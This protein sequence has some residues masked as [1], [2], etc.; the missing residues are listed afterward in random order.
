M[1]VFANDDLD[2]AQLRRRPAAADLR[3]RAPTPCCTRC[4]TSTRHTRGGMQ[5]RWRHRRLH[6]RRRARTA[7]RATCSASRTAP[8]TRDARRRRRWTRLVWVSRSRRAGMG[9]GRQLPRRPRHP[10]ARR[11]LGP[12]DDRAS[13][14]GCSA[15]ARTPARRCTGSRRPTPRLRRRPAGAAI[16][17]DA[18]IRMANPRTAGDA[19]AAASCAAAT[20]TTGARR[21]GNLDMGLVFNCFQQDL[22]RQFVAVQKR[23][24]DEPLVDYMSPVGGGY[25]FALP[26]VRDATDWYGSAC[27][28][29]ASSAVHPA[30]TD[31]PHLRRSPVR[32]SAP[33]SI[34]TERNPSCRS[35]AHQALAAGRDRGRRGG[36]PASSP[37]Q[38][39]TARAAESPRPTTTSGTTTPIKHLVVIFDENVSFDHYFAHLPEGREHRR[40]D[41]RGGEAHA[42][43]QQPEQRRTAH[44]QPEPVPADPA[45]PR[46]RR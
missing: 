4:A 40:H 17:L 33:R 31:L 24:A 14:S 25:F 38:G 28:P 10:D 22:D 19:T 11:V 16:P 30:F 45:R 32:T 6:S 44:P 3:G 23:L 41:V 21:N 37:R 8:P 13:R 36:R 2:R 1:D 20:T 39:A 26:G 27:S 9:G 29:D 35:R 18:H 7:R 46:R 42:E 43:G 5:V 34:P 15:A 12:R